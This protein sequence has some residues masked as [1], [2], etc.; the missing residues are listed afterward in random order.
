M[1]EL[2]E[3]AWGILDRLSWPKAVVDFDKMAPGPRDALIAAGAIEKVKT[4]AGK[5]ATRHRAMPP[6]YG[7]V[8]TEAGR[9]L[10]ADR[11]AQMQRAAESP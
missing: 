11:K 10:L 1:P 9:K 7:L 3:M 2:S 4:S 6:K 5:P 8:I